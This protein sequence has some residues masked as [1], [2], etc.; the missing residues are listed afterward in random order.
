M[1]LEEEIKMIESNIRAHQKKRRRLSDIPRK[2]GKLGRSRTGI[3]ELDKDNRNPKKELLNIAKYQEQLE[4]ERRKYIKINEGKFFLPVQKSLKSTNAAIEIVK[5]NPPG[6][7]D[8]FW[9]AVNIFPKK[10]GL[11]FLFNL[12]KSQIEN[13]NV[14]DGLWHLYLYIEQASKANPIR[15][16]LINFLSLNEDLKSGNLVGYR[17]TMKDDDIVFDHII[18]AS[19]NITVP[20]PYR[21]P[22]DLQIQDKGKT[23]DMGELVLEEYEFLIQLVEDSTEN[24]YEIAIPRKYIVNFTASFLPVLQEEE[25]FFDYL[26]DFEILN[27]ENQLF[28]LKNNQLSNS[29]KAEETGDELHTIVPVVQVTVPDT[30]RDLFIIEFSQFIERFI[31]PQKNILDTVE[32]KVKELNLLIEEEN[33]LAEYENKMSMDVDFQEYIEPHA[34]YYAEL[35]ILLFNF[36]QNVKDPFGTRQ[37]IFYFESYNRY[38]DLYGDKYILFKVPQA[39]IDRMKRELKEKLEK[40]N[41]LDRIMNQKVKKKIGERW[42]EV[43]E[44]LVSESDSAF[45]SMRKCLELLT[46]AHLMKLGLQVHTQKSLAERIEYCRRFIT[47]AIWN[48]MYDIKDIGNNAAHDSINSFTFIN[49]KKQESKV[50]YSK[51]VRIIKYYIN[52]IGI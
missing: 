7:I 32:E 6:S 25:L 23:P 51:F 18:P 35:H 34:K 22:I 19:I 31:L 45:L 8:L 50:I 5:S 46:E 42:N 14:K 1:Y 36:K 33:D 47:S 39:M 27:F 41:L 49:N 37:P 20:L 48:D 52:N 2:R 11:N 38:L 21:A 28:N 3:H 15:E 26:L 16:T 24:R 17:F 30:K 29:L 43:E 13:G 9:E 4:V 44:E 10:F 40:Q 12:G